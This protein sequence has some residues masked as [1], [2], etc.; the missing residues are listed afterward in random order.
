MTPNWKD[1]W[2]YLELNTRITYLTFILQKLSPLAAAKELSCIS[3]LIPYF[4]FPQYVLQSVMEVT[5]V[6][7]RVPGE[8]LMTFACRNSESTIL[9]A[10]N[11]Y[12]CDYIHGES[13]GQLQHGEAK[14]W[15]T[16]CDLQN[17]LTLRLLLLNVIGSKV[18]PLIF[19]N[20]SVYFQ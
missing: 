1:T 12:K 6:N 14:S 15:Y 13:Y 2:L 9:S 16:V 20:P 3:I 4:C 19:P 11:I 10:P 5:G 18:F 7:T 17:L 8:R